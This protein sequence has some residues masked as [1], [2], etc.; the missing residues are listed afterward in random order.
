MRIMRGH[1]HLYGILFFAAALS[2]IVLLS[3]CD[4]RNKARTPQPMEVSVEKVTAATMPVYSEFPGR[5]NAPRVA[6]VRARVTGVVK[7]QYFTEGAEVKEG[8]LLFLIDPDPMQAAYDSA[9]AS[10]EKA[11][12][13]LAQNEITAK[14][15]VELVK[16]GAV[17]QQDC[18]S[19]VASLAVQRAE[20]L[21]AKAA[22][23]TA[24]LNL[25]YTKVTAPIS[26][27]IGKAFVTEGALVSASALTE[28][29]LIQ[30]LDPIY[31]DFT[32]ANADVLK[33]RR[34]IASGKLFGP[35]GQLTPVSLYL[36]DGSVY[37]HTG[38]ILFA[39]ISVDETTGMVTLR[40]EFPNAEKLLLP[41]SFARI[42]I[43][44]AVDKNS[45]TV[46]QRSVSRG[47]DGSA[48]VFVVDESGKIE[49]RAITTG[50]AA[51]DKW[52]V[53]S[54]L[55]AGDLVVVEGLQKIKAGQ[56]VSTVPFVA[57]NA[58]TGG[59]NASVKGR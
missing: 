55:N 30:Q 20:V 15:Y 45:V 22:L 54:G 57:A 4:G 38:K 40:A 21:S 18:D 35:D 29:A 34:A 47:T 48:R 42:R 36:E 33:L 28:L 8:D 19:A 44:Q 10:L 3:G 49:I 1:K 52:V 51:G 43:S 13:N 37:E 26:G 17:S 41:G 53:T 7:K 5:V 6:E 27:R 56:T 16:V 59:A 46:Y 2:G 50:D 31:F 12:A 9:K 58:A 39:D 24:A 23:K 11:E 14:R 32:Q 25:G